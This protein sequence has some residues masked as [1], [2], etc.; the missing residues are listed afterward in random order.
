MPRPGRDFKGANEF[1]ATKAKH[2]KE[3]PV[4][5]WMIRLGVSVGLS[6]V[7]HGYNTD[8]NQ[9]IPR[10]IPIQKRRTKI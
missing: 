5:P 9:V 6:E 4:L 7:S 3:Y 10:F 8:T 1:R 2:F